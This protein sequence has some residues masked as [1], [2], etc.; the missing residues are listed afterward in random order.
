MAARAKQDADHIYVLPSL[1]VNVCERQAFKDWLYQKVRL[2]LYRW[3]LLPIN[4]GSNWKL[5]VADTNA[6]ICLSAAI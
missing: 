6:V 4:A 1:L 3:I 5:L 2:A